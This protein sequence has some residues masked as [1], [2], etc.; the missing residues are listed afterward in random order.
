MKLAALVGAGEMKVRVKAAMKVAISFV[1]RAAV[2]AV[3]KV[4]THAVKMTRIL[5]A[6]FLYVLLRIFALL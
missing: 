5:H 3:A 1:M 6:I 4:A 2:E